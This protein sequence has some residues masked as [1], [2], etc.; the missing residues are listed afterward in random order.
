MERG[1]LSTWEWANEDSQESTE[2]AAFTYHTLLVEGIF[3]DFL[4]D[5]DDMA[6][7]CRCAPCSRYLLIEHRL[8][9]F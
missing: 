5:G 4:M 9:S 8:G 1:I 3:G 2:V 7:V 6:S